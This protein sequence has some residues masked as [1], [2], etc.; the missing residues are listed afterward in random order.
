M[1]D[2][3]VHASS[4]RDMLRVPFTYVPVPNVHASSF[5][6]MLRV[7]FTYV[8]VPNVQVPSFGDMLRVPF[9]YVR[10]PNVHAPLPCKPL[11]AAQKRLN[12]LINS[13]RLSAAVSSDFR[14]SKPINGVPGHASL[15]SSPF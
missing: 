10:E 15:S 5:R 4:L 2:P 14:T 13:G 8:R 12:V 6:D 3:N 7:P 11:R 9:T 1:P